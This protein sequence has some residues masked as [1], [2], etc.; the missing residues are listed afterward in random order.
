MH[1]DTL[2][3]QNLVHNYWKSSMFCSPF[4]W[5]R[6]SQEIHPRQ[7]N[8]AWGLSLAAIWV[9]PNNR[10]FLLRGKKSP[11]VASTLHRKN[12]KTK[13]GVFILKTHQILAKKNKQTKH[14]RSKQRPFW[15][16]L[17]KTRA[18]KSRDY[19]DVIVLQSSVFQN[20]FR[21]K[22]N[23]VFSHS[24]RLKSVL[25][26]LRFCDGL[27]IGEDGRPNRKTKAAVFEF[28]QR[29]LD[30]FIS[31]GRKL[32]FSTCTNPIIHLFYPPKIWIG[33]VLNYSWDMLMSQEKLQTKSM[34][35]FWGVREVHYGIVQV[36]NCLGTPTW[37]PWRQ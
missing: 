2:N 27:L 7:G 14:A 15:T 24:F 26:K 21:P 20:V 34:Q 13:N 28:I 12:L 35:N 37:P 6:C 16:C 8:I 4:P 11:P 23:P 30:S 9:I 25:E 1:F 31:Q 5:Q 32:Q 10:R 17:R 29:S 19:R 33:I 22:R 3:I 36:V 18:G